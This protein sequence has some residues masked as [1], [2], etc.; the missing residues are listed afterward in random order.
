MPNWE[1][2]LWVKRRVLDDEEG[3]T[4]NGLVMVS[5]NKGFDR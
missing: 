1:G 4:I 2:F 5:R 3:L